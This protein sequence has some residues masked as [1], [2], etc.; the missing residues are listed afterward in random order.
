[1]SH[2]V[3]APARF[4][5]GGPAAADL[6]G[7]IPRRGLVVFLAVSFAVAWAAFGLI[8]LSGGF[9]G[10]GALLLLVAMYGPALG[11]LATWA[12]GGPMPLLGVRRRGRWWPYLVAWLGPPCALGLGATLAAALGVQPFDPTLSRLRQALEQQGASFVQPPQE[13][14]VLLT[15]VSVLVGALLNTLA[16]FGEEV[17]WRGYLLAA[18]SPL[19]GRR[20]ALL[21]GL[22]W[23]LWHVPL[24]AQGWNYPGEPLLGSLLMVLFALAWGIILAWLRLRADSMWPAALGHGAVNAAGSSL[25]AFF[26]PDNPLLGAPVGLVVQVPSLLWALWLLRSP[27][28]K[29]TPL[30][31]A[32]PVRTPPA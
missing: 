6:N 29:R 11:T 10:P 8:Q 20:A 2:E 13:M 14:L 3:T 17:G 23:G 9:G 5:I 7:E 22:I 25:V 30:L 4:P 12:W 18:L 28:W 26:P 1:M 19:G 31:A 16:A 15:V 32:R 27:V 24:I 21:T